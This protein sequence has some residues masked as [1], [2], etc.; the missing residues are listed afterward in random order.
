[1]ATARGQLGLALAGFGIVLVVVVLAMIFA[2]GGGPLML[3]LGAGYPMILVGLALA[4][5][6]KRWIGG[7]LVLVVLGGAALSLYVVAAILDG[8]SQGG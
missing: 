7:I 3:A 1:M 8:V 2:G 6:E 5:T 4:A